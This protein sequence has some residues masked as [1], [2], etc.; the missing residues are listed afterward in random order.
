MSIRTFSW[1]D[2]PLLLKYRSR[3]LYLD[4]V[5]LLTR[6]SMTVPGRAL[7]SYLFPTSG[8]VTCLYTHRSNTTLPLIGQ[9]QH[10]LG[11]SVARLSFLT[12]SDEI[13]ITKLAALLEQLI[14]MLV[15][16]GALHLLAEVDE[17]DSTFEILRQAG[18]AIY[19]RQRIWQITSSIASQSKTNE[20]R[21]SKARDT[22]AVRALYA[23]LVPGLVQ[24]VEKP[25]PNHQRGLVFFQKGE[26]LAFV[27]VK[28]GLRGIWAQ[29][30]IHP[31]AEG[32]TT[33]LL[34][35]LENLPNRR[36]R[37][38]YLCIRTYQSWLESE[39][40]DYGA[41]AGSLQAVMVKH[42]AVS[43]RVVTPVKFRKIE[44]GQSTAPLARSGNE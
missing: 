32:I 4:N 33:S 3:G 20:W 30:F 37:P 17:L 19:A 24:Q 44:A 25:P 27:D 38:V 21:L 16:R 2:L 29:P 10:E 34:D 40:V 1:R 36:N 39:I 8:N 26:L 13:E 42:L 15:V 28:F 5:L 18:F 14:S 23:N 11:T 31:D 9:V 7:L 43:Q 22:L 12:P 35:F 41:Q 6:D